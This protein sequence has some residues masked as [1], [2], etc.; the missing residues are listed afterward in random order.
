MLILKSFCVS[1]VPR[2]DQNVQGFTA[3]YAF[4]YAKST[5]FL[6]FLAQK[7]PVLP[8]V[9]HFYAFLKGVWGWLLFR[10]FS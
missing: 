10:S 8:S 3:F 5:L 7:T 2:G 4:A 1:A 9:L 6:R